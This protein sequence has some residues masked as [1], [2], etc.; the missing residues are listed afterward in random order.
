M[1]NRRVDWVVV[2]TAIA[3]ALSGCGG[4][5][6]GCGMT[7]IPGGF[8]VAK[9]APNAAQVRVTPTALAAISADPAAVIAPL[10]G[11]AMNGVI[12]FPVPGSCGGNPEIC[13][14]NG[15][16]AAACGP[17]QIDLV[18]RPNDEPRLVLTPVAGQSRLDMTI[19]ARVKTVMKMPI[20]Y[21]TGIFTVNCDVTID[22]TK[23]SQADL[24][25]DAQIQF[26]QDPTVGTTR[27]AANNVSV[28]Q[29]ESADVTLS[30][31]VGCTIGGAFIGLF[32]GTLQTQI[33]SVI[34]STINDATCKACD[35]GNVAD[36]G[37]SL[38]TACTNKV[39]QVGNRCL[40]EI[41]LD[42]RMPAVSLFGGLSPGTTGA[43]DLYE[44]T[45]G[46]A[47]SEGGG[48]A[49]G[50]LGGMQP[51]GT[52]R[53]KCGP[54]ATEPAAVT[55]PQSAVFQ[56]NTVPGTTTPFDIGI[57]LH[58]SQLSQFGWAGYD[59]GLLCL[60]IGNSTVAQL[61]TD[62]LSLLSRS[63]GDLVEGSSPMAVGL[64]PQSPPVITLGKNTFK[65]DGTGNM[66]LD[67]PLLDIKFTGME[68]DMFASIDDQY[69]RVFTVVSDVHLPIG[70]Q[71]MGMGK[72]T[73]VIGAIDDAF[74]NVSV[75]NS[76]AVTESPQQLAM[77]FPTLLNLVL[78]QLSGGLSPISLPAIGGLNLSVVSITSVDND[79]FLA[80]FANLVT[81][82]PLIAPV[83][84][85]VKVAAQTEAAKDI[86]LRPSHWRDAAAPSVTLDFGPARGLEYSYRINGGTWSAWSPSTH[87]TVRSQVF[88]LAGTHKIEVLA[89]EIGKPETIAETPETLSVV[90]GGEQQVT[91]KVPFHGQAGAS[92]CACDSGGAGAAAAAPFAL[93]ILMLLLPLRRIRR[94]LARLGGVVWLAAM[95]CLPGC[96]CG[97]NAPCGDV[98]CLE[99]EVPNGGL[100][101][102][103]SIAADDKRV[104]VATYDTGLGDLVVVD[105]TDASKPKYTVVDGVPADF[106]PTYDPGTYRGGI[107]D[108]GP[109]VGAW[110]AI[111][112]SGGHGIVAYQDRETHALKVAREKGEG[113]WT[114]YT[115]DTPDGDEE[116]GSHAS[117]AI[118]G[119]GHPAI[120]YLAV[121][122][123]DGMGHRATELRLVRGTSAQPDVSDWST[124]TITTGIGTCAGLCGSG[125]ACIAG[126]A[127]GDPQT[128][129]AVTSDC[130]A[131]CASGDVCIAGACTTEIAKPTT[132]TLATGTGIFVNLNTL[133]DGRLAATYYDRTNRALVLA[134]ETAAGSSAFMETTL[135]SATPGDRGMWASTV[136]DGSGTIHVAYQ[137]AL[138]DQLMYTSY[139]GTVGTPEVVDDGI[140][141]GDRPHT[142]GAGASIFL[143]NGTPTIAYQDG[144]TADIYVAS[145][146]GAMWSK[147]PR[148]AGPLLDGFAIAATVG[149]NGPVA[150][151]GEI[152]PASSPNRL[153]MIGTP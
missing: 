136:V 23:G 107:E 6:G 102:F 18:K 36:C 59:G 145:K 7:T 124:S 114:S 64:R 128:C 126:A 72:I 35:S 68:I 103:N 152:D 90:F 135:D 69:V 115:L 148:I 41:G 3:I 101:R 48:L 137:E 93:M 118:D 96:S 45:G 153:L 133:P 74:T 17:L 86:A 98:D 78:P 104:L 22:T 67:Q 139:A 58:K 76:E 46:Y 99:G 81:A 84:N 44:V 25:I 37:S 129:A 100:G 127:A 131:Q 32:T 138:G 20:K 83:D 132:T 34:S 111:A 50:L 71:V 85:H 77:L 4:G 47:T 109:D 56:G 117:I 108:P 66:V 53:D 43:L 94:R 57:G 79:S 52:E 8:P 9:R 29:L 143:A 39:C 21:D 38:A 110:T 123:D 26:S 51:G 92:G 14:V 33:A 146:S 116:I 97:S 54:S 150:A 31:S 13:C 40:Q 80:I 91:A 10:V 75:K 42:G 140:R 122:T 141:T 16:P 65:D 106:T 49:L 60:T 62:T 89:R 149:P 63:L 95:A 119:S 151:W 30:G 120:A 142:V 55:V 28:T 112:L 88:F 19:R 61:N 134:L 125:T 2:L 70:L 144:L 15:Q 11:N 27:I 1:N 82:T 130:A 24:R 5:C 113:D 147:A 87:P 73:P 121:G 12:T 105:G